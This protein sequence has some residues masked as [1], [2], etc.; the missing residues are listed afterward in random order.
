MAFNAFSDLRLVTLYA[1]PEGILAHKVNRKLNHNLLTKVTQR[2]VST[3]LANSSATLQ[4]FDL[5]DNKLSTASL[6]LSSF[7]SLT[8]L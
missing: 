1:H 8:D 6:E 2:M 4:T 3:G 5:S 7:T